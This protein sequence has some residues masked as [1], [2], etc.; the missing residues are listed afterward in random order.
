MLE[1]IQGPW[2]WYVSG[3]LIGLMVPAL[4]LL[5]GKPLGIS[6][7]FQCLASLAKPRRKGTPL[8]DSARKE[9]WKVLFGLG[10]VLGGFVAARF[11]SAEA[12]HLF[13]ETFLSPA[14]ALQLL[15]GGFLVGFGS[16]YAQGCTSGHAIFGLSTLQIGS[17]VAV[18]GF[19]AG[20]LSAAGFTLLIQ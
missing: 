15:L 13:P 14:G 19:F 17:L 1:T 16:R 12:L 8:P 11:L 5:A 10:M 4:L 3:P 7:S 2:P 20:G 6:S 18:A 9:G